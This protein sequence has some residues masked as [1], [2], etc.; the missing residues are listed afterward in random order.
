M[1]KEN[2]VEKYLHRIKR[3]R[4]IPSFEA[5]HEEIISDNRLGLDQRGELLEVLKKAALESWYRSCS[6]RFE[7]IHGEKIDDV[8]APANFEN[9]VSYL[10]KAI[11]VWALRCIK[12]DDPNYRDIAKLIILEYIPGRYRRIPFD[13]DTTRSKEPYRIRGNVFYFVKIREMRSEDGELKFT[14]TLYRDYDRSP[15]SIV[16]DPNAHN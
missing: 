3:L 14:V 15:Q 7:T 11:E 5:V 2:L 9:R 4:I 13:T 12:D 6:K 16:V 1:Y 10:G 8:D